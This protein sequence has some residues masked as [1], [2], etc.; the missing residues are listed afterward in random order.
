MFDNLIVFQSENDY[1]SLQKKV[2][3]DWQNFHASGAMPQA[4]RSVISS[5]WERCKL[6]NLNPLKASVPQPVSEIELQ[7]RC[8][9]EEGWTDIVK[10]YV[11]EFTRFFRD[12][13]VLGLADC[14]GTIIHNLSQGYHHSQLEK[15][16]FLVGVSWN[17]ETIGTNSVGTALIEKK[18]V[19]ILAEEHYCQALHNLLCSAVPILDPLTAHVIGVL[20]FPMD[21]NKIGIT[22]MFA[23]I[24]QVMKMERAIGRR[25]IEANMQAMQAVFNATGEPFIIYDRNG[26]VT[27]ATE[28]AQACF[29]IAKGQSISALLGTELTVLAQQAMTNR[30]APNEAAFRALDGNEWKVSFLPYSTVGRASGGI[31][32]FRKV[33]AKGNSKKQIVPKTRYQFDHIITADPGMEKTIALAKKAAFSEKSVMITGETGTG[34]EMF[35]QS[36][37]AHGNRKNEPFVAINCGAIP[38]EL[39]ASELFGYEGGAFTGAKPQGKKGKFL[40]ADKGTIFLDEIGE[41]PLDAQVYLLRVLEEKMVLPIGAAQPVPV[42]V[43]VIAATHKDLRKEVS[44]GNFREDLYY[45]LQIINLS[46]PSLRMRKN[47]L[48]LLVQHFLRANAVSGSIPA[49]STEGWDVLRSWSWPGNVRQLK[50]V[51]EQAV[52]QC[53]DGVIQPEDLPEEIRQKTV[54]EP[55]QWTYV[56]NRKCHKEVLL[57]VLAQTN[58][59][60]AKAAA[61]LD[62]SRVT[63]YRKMKQYKIGI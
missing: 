38:K 62:V 51:M 31:A 34:K 13:T 58:G 11:D 20:S 43:R 53:S 6:H 39:L 49:I 26:I 21:K 4:Q 16:G 28:Y 30:H 33:A 57:E 40:L 54:S 47:D 12:P 45:R 35:A 56:T 59:N 60:V 55:E 27:V 29:G 25:M 42:N 24:E 46:I 3:S 19:Q 7:E 48:P 36:I 17:E 23:L 41:M 2:L 32:A 63:I 10:G 50:N 14:D 22:E 15:K 44:K 18:P 1:R 5:S 37:H 52:F 61:I 8:L 9:M